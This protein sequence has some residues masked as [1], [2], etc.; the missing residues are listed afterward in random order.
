VLLAGDAAHIHS[1]AGGQGM[2]LG[3]QDA[4]ALAAALRADATAA[5]AKERRAVGRR[6]LFATDLA[7]R[8][9]SLHGAISNR[10]REGAL[11]WALARP[12]IARRLARGIGGLAYPPIPD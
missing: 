7:T 6:V 3:I 10:L 9:L 2:N 8:L 11:R 1:P 4:Y 5:W 12:P